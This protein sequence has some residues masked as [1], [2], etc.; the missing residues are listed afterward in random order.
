MV[1]HLHRDAPGFGFIEGAGGVAVEGCPGICVDFR[2]EGGFQGF[3]G[4][5]GAEEVGVADEE[6]FFVVVGVDKPAGDAVGAV[7]AD[8]A[9]V[10]M[11]DV[12]AVDFDLDLIIFR[13]ENIDVGFAE[14]DEQIALAGIF[15][16][17][18]HVQVGVHAGLEHRDAAEF[19]EL[20]GMGVVIEGAGD[21][22]VEI[23]ITGF[24]GGG[25]QIGA[26]NGAELGADED[27][28]AFLLA[29]FFAAFEITA[30]GADQ[31]AGPGGEGGE[32]DLIFLVGLLHA[33][34]F[35]V[36]QNHLRKVALFAVAV[37]SIGDTRWHWDRSVRRFHPRPARGGAKGF[38][39]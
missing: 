32:V 1:D 28:G 11:E 16:I 15:E 14:D 19:V 25:D 33:G 2:L 36:F 29:V 4:I 23:R 17:V 3:V 21:E 27:G 18:G 26:G 35:E 38:P 10:G 24:A 31:V 9:G 8:F 39:R 7:G 6:S 12:H 37:R 34:G 22:H 5:V 30:F 20:G 13:V